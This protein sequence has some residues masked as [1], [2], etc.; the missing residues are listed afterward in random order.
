MLEDTAISLVLHLILGFYPCIVLLVQILL[1]L[2]LYAV[3]QQLA[4][5]LGSIPVGG[6]AGGDT[7]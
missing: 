6:T 7:T 4:R 1:H 5:L 3:S 2:R